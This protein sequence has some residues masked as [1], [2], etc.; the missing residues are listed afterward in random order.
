MKARMFY[1][2]AVLEERQS[3]QCLLELS[4]RGSVGSVGS[5]FG[6]EKV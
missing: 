1:I 3:W 6:V 5:A 2:Y 4:D